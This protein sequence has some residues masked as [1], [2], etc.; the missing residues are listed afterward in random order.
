V[1]LAHFLRITSGLNRIMR[2][3]LKYF[4][5]YDN[6]KTTVTEKQCNINSVSKSFDYQIKKLLE[7]GENIRKNAIIVD[8]VI[9]PLKDGWELSAIQLNGYVS[10]RKNSKTIQGYASFLG[11]RISS[12]AVSELYSKR[13]HDKQIN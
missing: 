12:D 13:N 4:G 11:H 5:F 2:K 8:N 10:I 9:F 1:Q 3:I 6:G 7:E